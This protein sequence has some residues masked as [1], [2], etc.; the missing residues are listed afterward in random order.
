MSKKLTKL[1]QENIMNYFPLNNS[2][3]FLVVT[4]SIFWTSP[5]RV[6]QIYFQARW[7]KE[8]LIKAML[9]GSRTLVVS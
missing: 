7:Y 9:E 8:I 4:S 6:I 3:Y 1:Q 5:K 2:L